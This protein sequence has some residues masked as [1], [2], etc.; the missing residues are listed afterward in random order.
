M[1]LPDRH[2][3]AS[4]S[5]VGDLNVGALAWQ[6]EYTEKKKAYESA[7]LGHESKMSKLDSEVS[8]Y[9]EELSSAESQ[10]HTVNCELKIVDAYVMRVAQVRCPS[11]CGVTAWIFWHPRARVTEGGCGSLSA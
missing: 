1:V 4:F 3:V 8:G 5:Q 10:Y 9:K 2:H 7:K 6:A 11:C